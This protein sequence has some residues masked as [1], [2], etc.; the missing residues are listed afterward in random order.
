MKEL[1]YDENVI[2]MNQRPF[3]PWSVIGLLPGQLCL[4]PDSPESSVPHQEGNTR[5]ELPVK[6][7][8]APIS[9]AYI[10]G[11]NL[12][13]NEA[14]LKRSC[15]ELGEHLWALDKKWR[16]VW[17]LVCPGMPLTVS[18]R[19]L[20]EPQELWSSQCPSSSLVWILEKRHDPT[21]DRA[22]PPP[23]LG[24][25]PLSGLPPGWWLSLRGLQPHQPSSYCV[26]LSWP[27]LVRRIKCQAEAQEQMMVKHTCV[28]SFI[29]V[30][31]DPLLVNLT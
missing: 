24:L 21:R 1:L 9:C 27:S 20:G 26:L 4:Y 30:N 16:K 11:Y 29:L 14:K 13:W 22:G 10:C 17:L 2:S 3:V 28:L 12:F 7:L 23:P 5:H 15:I 19:S 25:P 18:E 6:T 8:I 31:T